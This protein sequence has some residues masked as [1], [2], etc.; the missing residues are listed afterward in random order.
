M[1]VFCNY[2]E[3]HEMS[4][5]ANLIGSLTE[6]FLLFI[7]YLCNYVSYMNVSTKA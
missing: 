5:C 6:V 3:V 2:A 1:S 4:N 7:A